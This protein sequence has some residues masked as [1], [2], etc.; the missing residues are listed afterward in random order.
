MNGH[1]RQSINSYCLLCR[2]VNLFVSFYFRNNQQYKNNNHNTTLMKAQPNKCSCSNFTAHGLFLECIP[3][4]ILMNEENKVRI[5]NIVS[6]NIY[7]RLKLLCYPF[8]LSLVEIIFN[9]VIQS[10]GTV[11]GHLLYCMWSHCNLNYLQISIIF[12]FT[13]N[14]WVNVL[15]LLLYTSSA[16][17]YNHSFY[18]D[19]EQISM[20][21]KDLYGYSTVRVLIVLLV[22]FNSARPTMGTKTSFIISTWVS[23]CLVSYKTCIEKEVVTKL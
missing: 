12:L 8:L 10:S 5:I 20:A 1:L 6:Q 4:R 21:Q 15:V 16:P 18:M 9:Q 19:S 13:W 2:H 11:I 3:G 7:Y 23:K 17:P 14:D 22:Y